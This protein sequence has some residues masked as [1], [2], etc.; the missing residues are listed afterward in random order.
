MI[1]QQLKTLQILILFHVMTAIDSLV[2]A[3]NIADAM[4]ALGLC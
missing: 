3:D 4:V 1:R 2:S